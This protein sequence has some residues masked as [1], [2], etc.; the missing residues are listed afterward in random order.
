MLSETE[1]GVIL[2]V[3][4]GLT[5]R[6]EAL[7][8][9]LPPKE[10]L[11]TARKHQIAPLLL[12]GAV[13]CGL[14]QDS[15]VMQKLLLMA[16]QT[17]SAGEGQQIALRRLYAALD[18]AGL[19]YLPLKGSVLR[20]LYPKPELRAMSDADIL[21]RMEQV[22]EVEALLRRLGYQKGVESDHELHWSAPGLH[23]E[24]H[25]RLFPSYDADLDACFRDV[26]Q[27][28]V[29]KRGS[30]FGLTD[31]D[32]FLYLFAHFAKHYRSGGVGMK[33]LTDLWV[34]RQSKPQLR[35]K[36][37]LT[38]LRT[39]GLDAF[40]RNVMAAC[41]FW[42]AGAAPAEKTEL[43]SRTVLQSGAFGPAAAQ[44]VAWASRLAPE[45]AS[46][47]KASL[48]WRMETLFLPYRRMCEL[49]PCLK[50]LPVL[51]PALWVVRW[52]R[53]LL[54]HRGRLRAERAVF[55]SVSPETVAAYR[56][57]LREAGLRF[58]NDR[59]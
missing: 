9:E 50:R 27:R 52:V 2:L 23:L 18:E 6:R 10:L 57:A 19:D 33:H 56:S 11:H 34:Y 55:R 26:W 16:A 37:L 30:R 15:P 45:N 40:Y 36:K 53:A 58:P 54:F 28:A 32:G 43:I 29:P 13:C 44:A 38:A 21:I 3:R 31:E 48:R 24:L 51:L 25:K 22:N 12:E 7:P 1:R 35:E 59:A 5:G 49:Y 39:L 8:W 42:F 41:A 47:R 14:P 17:I 20:E 4:A 46:G